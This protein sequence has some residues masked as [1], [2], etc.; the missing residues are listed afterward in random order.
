MPFRYLIVASLG[1]VLGNAA[2]EAAVPLASPIK[3]DQLDVEASAAIV[4]GTPTTVDLPKLISV[5]GLNEKANNERWEGG[6]MPPVA[7]AANELQYRIAFKSPVTVGSL[8]VYGGPREA[9]L[10]KADAPYPGDPAN[11]EHWITLNIPRRQATGRTA[12]F[13]QPVA[14]RAVLLTDRTSRGRSY[15]EGLRIWSERLH[16]VTPLSTAYADRE[17]DKPSG[18][19]S[20]PFLYRAMLVSLGAGQPWIS[21]GPNRD[22]IVPVPP[23][24]DVAPS[25]FMLTWNEAQSI[26]GLWIDGNLK[27]FELDYFVGPDAVNPRA[28][29]EAEWR[30]IADVARL[31]KRGTWLGFAAVKTRGIRLRITKTEDGPVAEIRSLHA[32]SDLGAAP[33]PEWALASAA[34]LS[35]ERLSPKQLA[36]EMPYAGKLTVVIDGPDGRRVRNVIG[37]QTFEAGTQ[38]IAWNLQDEN[39]RYV[40]P[41]KYTWK[42]IAHPPLELKYEQTVYP[43]VAQ[44]APENAPWQ[45]KH[46]GPDGWLADHTAPVAAAALGD[47]MY[48]GAPT[49]ESGVALIECDLEGRRQWGHHDFAAWTG[50]R[51]L[52]ADG[53]TLFVGARMGTTDMVWTVDPATHKIAQLLKLEPSGLSKRG[54][55]YLAAHDGKL[56]MSVRGDPTWLTAA[57]SAGDVDIEQCLP[58]YAPTRKALKGIS[59]DKRGDF[60]RLFRLQGT[61]PGK[62]TQDSLVWLETEK[63]SGNQLH[64]LLSF[65]KEIPLGS[66]VLSAPPI[67]DAV[68][69][70]SVLKPGA[71]YP[72]NVHDAAQ[73]EPLP[74]PATPQWDCIPAPPGTNTRA[75][76]LTF[77]RGNA[78]NDANDP[79]ASLLD[80]GKKSDVPADPLD[81]DAKKKA[82]SGLGGFDAGQW[83]G[84]LEGLKLLRRRFESRLPSATIR[85]N[86]GTVKGMTWDAERTAPLTVEAP[87]IY[88]MEWQEPQSLQGL[89]I[90]EIDGKLTK[91]DVYEGDASAAIDIDAADGWREVATYEQARR[92]WYQP[93]ANRNIEARYLD[94]Y[95]D[96]GEEVKTRA[97]RLRVVEQWADNGQGRPWGSREDLGGLSIEPARC[98][99]YGV[100]PLAYVGGELP[101]DEGLSERLEIY[102][103]A[104]G[105]RLHEVPLTK[106]GA[107]A[108]DPQGQLFAVSGTQVVRVDVGGASATPVVTDLV[109]PTALAFD[110]D[111][112]LYA[113]DMTPERQNV[114][115]YDS[116]GKLLREVGTPGGFRT[117]A[118]DPTRLGKITALSVD[119][120]GQLWIVENQFYPKRITVWA[121]DGTFLREHLGNTEY[122]GGGVL[123]PQDRTRL[124]VG[125]LEFT[126]DWEKGTS[127]LKNLTWLGSTPPGEVPI[128]ANGKLY[129]VTRPRFADQECGI[130][131]L[132]DDGRLK[133]A[134]AAGRAAAFAPLKNPAVI[135]K[136]GNV[137][138][139]EH[140][141]YW[142][143]LNDDGAVQA[144][145]M[146]LT[147]EKQRPAAVSTFDADLSI[148]AQTVRYQVKGVTPGGAPIYGEELFSNLTAR[149]HY[150]LGDGN[151]HRLGG[152]P[153]SSEAQVAPDGSEIWTH[154]SEGATVQS[155]YGAGPWHTDQV[156]AQF[157]KVGHVPAD[158]SPIGEFVVFHGNTGG[159]NIWTADGLLLGPIFHDQ[160]DGVAR[161]WSM[162]EHARG[163]ILENLMPGQEHFWG[164]F[165]RS[166]DGKF[167]VVAGHNHVSILEVLGLERAVRT[168]G[169]IDVSEADLKNTQQ[170]LANR[171]QQEVYTRAPVVDC[172]RV[173]EAP[174]IDGDLKDWRNGP[175]AT[176]GGDRPPQAQF[177]MSYDEQNLYLAYGTR[178]LGPLKNA[179]GGDFQRLFKTGAAV[180]LQLQTDPTADGVRQVPVA[181]DI[182]LLLTFV[183]NEPQAVV[184]R[185]VAPGASPGDAYQ[186]ASPVGEVT[187]DRIERIANVKMA[188]NSTGDSY[189]LEAAVPLAALGFR[190][191]D[192]MR[193]KM[194]WG[195]L[196]SGPDGN[197][198]IRRVYW[199]NQA[200][201][202][203]ADAPSE[204]RL[205]PNLW[206]HVLV[207][208]RKRTAEDRLDAFDKPPMP[209]G[210]EDLLDGK[211]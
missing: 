80:G 104:D 87:G 98:R 81:P 83:Q 41:G 170:W 26:R 165:C 139:P 31:D 113:A 69:K 156:V 86:S 67:K 22:N 157:G 115:V 198:V 207:H 193:L 145:E 211:K 51:W 134:A 133:L 202:I 146:K 47:K 124:L 66:V 129:F 24:S 103:A 75:L 13:E 191:T 39:G 12:T 147:D 119:S 77:A 17:Y 172:Y 38:S 186:I 44:F 110:A 120:R 88:V 169:T 73:W 127:R 91:I 16:N 62:A 106:P 82:S 155:L 132:Y 18:N 160:R 194:D 148:Q 162:K 52:A 206:G 185:A 108:Y 171:Q 7:G 4:N 123:D 150:R 128:R 196:M 72:P 152:G 197:E 99:V 125:P 89:A 175:N 138:L 159:W 168:Q 142:S 117:G 58:M 151:F 189:E 102:A 161:P 95:V 35:D 92:Y 116:N 37:R 121:K 209:K 49:A 136:I 141:F 201:N 63:A 74:T 131:Y 195:M 76:R 174:A 33:V 107:V 28:G 118:W 1:F 149:P 112:N 163:T 188:R 153:D 167:R 79:L 130:V 46:D 183:G 45:T 187:F 57:A 53:K 137:S 36:V 101:V 14:T 184:Y 64:V 192:G 154:R 176:I 43:N 19:F 8:L 9:A 135:A 158:Q 96:F 59:T 208:D 164:W 105:K 94:G 166:E 2:L 15:L 34:T 56:A 50:P 40:S 178:G 199:S 3:V 20:S 32:L 200:T 60:L 182:R 111:G 78:K 90:R 23:I 5:L 210:L 71:P 48:L 114:R 143:D 6:P 85:V 109:A 11:P 65:Q 204:A 54:M 205:H 100:V 179:G 140:R 180:D 61:P 21:A 27:N 144:D 25:W 70:V 177:Y 190:P 42:A 181:G 55:Q 68:L 173:T 30:K 126:L 97:V 122:G 10:L 93:D 84:R 203:V 29:V